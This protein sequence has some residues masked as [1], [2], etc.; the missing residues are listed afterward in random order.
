MTPA[1]HVIA[2][3]SSKESSNYN[4][5]VCFAGV[6]D[7]GEA[8]EK[9]NISTNIRKKLKSL[10]GLSTGARRSCSKKKT[11]GEKYGGTV[12]LKILI[13]PNVI[14]EHAT[15]T[16]LVRC[17]LARKTLADIKLL[18]FVKAWAGNWDFFQKKDFLCS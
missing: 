15:V 18:K 16:Q 2:G 17:A 8:P 13:V 7:T 11:R 9:S 10:L 4:K 6:T 1:K 5:I 12:P 3:V 14:L